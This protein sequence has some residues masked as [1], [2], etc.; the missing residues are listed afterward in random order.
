MFTVKISVKPGNE[1]PGKILNL[2]NQTHD[3]VNVEN[4]QIVLYF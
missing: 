3:A 4:V 1:G 2:K